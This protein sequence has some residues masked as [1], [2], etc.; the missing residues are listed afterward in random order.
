MDTNQY[1]NTN[2]PSDMQ[3]TNNFAQA[4]TM[5]PAVVAALALTNRLA[6][7]APAQVQNVMQVQES[8]NSVQNLLT[9]NDVP[10]AQ[11]MVFQNAQ[12][13]RQMHDLSSGILALSRGS[14][15]PSGDSVD[16]LSL[17]LL[18]AFARGRFDNP[19]YQL[20]LAIV[21]NLT[22]NSQTMTSAQIDENINYALIILRAGDVPTAFSYPIG[23]DL[24]AIALELQPNLEM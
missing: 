22:C 12:F 15:R 4:N 17:D 21:C 6:V 13:Q 10:N 18:R 20:V 14:L 5:T 7:M 2:P 3:P 9:N 8:L 1:V 24:R 19:D 11:Q 16:R 23:C